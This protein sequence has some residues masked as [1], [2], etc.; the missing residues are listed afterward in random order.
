[1]KRDDLI[2]ALVADLR[3][4]RPDR[5]AWL[6]A[7]A[8]AGGFAAALA[9]ALAWLGPRPDLG[10]ALGDAM[11]WMKAGYAAALAAGGFWSAE[12][13]ARPASRGRGGLLVAAAALGAVILAAALL[14]LPM[15]PERRMAMWMGHTWRLC[16]VFILLLSIPGLALSLLAMRRFAPTRPRLAGAAAGLFAGGLA[17]VAYGLHCDEA[18]AAFLATWYSLGVALSAGLGALAGPWA[19]RWR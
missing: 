8:A 10:P 16:P 3:P 9:L 5:V 15:P 6:I 2:E 17:A 19:L 14:T 1:V 11:F 12:R 7:G 4:V 13:L 18:G